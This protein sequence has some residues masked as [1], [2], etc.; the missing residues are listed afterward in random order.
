MFSV[1]DK[2]KI[3]A[4]IETVLLEIG[5]PEMPDEK[6]YFEIHIDGKESWSFADIKPNWF[7][8]E[9]GS[10]KNPNSWNE[11]AGDGMKGINNE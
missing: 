7:Y 3:A 9:Q 10:P 1:E 2:K 8:N 4:A 6:P 11:V 5:H